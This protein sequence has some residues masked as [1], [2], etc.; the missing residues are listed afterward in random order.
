MK[1]TI[2]D[3][4]RACGLSA[5]TV[6]NVLNGRRELVREDTRVRVLEAVR[7][8]GY[9][10]TADRPG[11]AAQRTRNIA[12]LA[13]AGTASRLHQLPY[14]AH[15]L[16]GILSATEDADW[17]AT[18]VV[19]S[20]LQDPD[21]FIRDRLEGRADVALAISPY[22][23]SPILEALVLRGFP[24]VVCA[25]GHGDAPVSYVDIDNHDALYQSTRYLIKLGHERIA[26]INGWDRTRPAIERASGFKRAM[27][28]SGLERH[29]IDISGDYRE[30]LAPEVCANALKIIRKSGATAVLCAN[31]Y[32]AVELIR[33]AE[34][35]NFKVSRDLSVVGFD[36]FLPNE[37]YS[38]RLTTVVYP[39][40]DVAYRAT[41]IAFEQSEL[42]SGDSTA[43]V[44]FQARLQVGETTAPPRLG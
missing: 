16:D 25:G 35:I 6:S 23:D 12:C 31:D 27:E 30:E 14:F 21:R 20:E 34:S 5:A 4:A 36:S 37:S 26:I 39:L 38:R 32:F 33:Q 41:K 2:R 8:L 24:T 22:Q 18:I 42:R 44:R 15:V 7:A 3:V 1:V 40:R 19:R 29:A 17:T 43:S 11:V 13:N 28:E 10:A 9:R